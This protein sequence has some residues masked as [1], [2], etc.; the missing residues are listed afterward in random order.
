MELWRR[1]AGPWGNEMVLGISWDLM[2]LAIFLAAAF[3]V[4]HALWSWLRQ[5]GSTPAAPADEADAPDVPERVTRHVLAARIFH[6]TMAASMIA[7]L[8]TAFGPVLGWQFPWLTIHWVSGFVLLGTIIFHTF[9]ALARGRFLEMMRI[10]LAEGMAMVRHA[11]SHSEPPPKSGKYPFDHRLFHHAMVVVGLGVILTGV[12]MTFRIDT[13]FWE[14]NP[15]ILF[16]DAVWSVVYV[17]HG[18]C[19]VALILLT[20]AHVYFGLRPDK[21]WL[22]WG[23]IRGWIGRDRYLEHYDPA[24]WAVSPSSTAPVASKSDDG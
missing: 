15:Y 1:A 18:L 21:F 12:T 24:K 17:L 11:S 8:V 6:W 20:V 5:R 3:L 4:V 13:W 23:M 22:T 19:G 2:W 7:L 10:G 16:P 14:A 9:H